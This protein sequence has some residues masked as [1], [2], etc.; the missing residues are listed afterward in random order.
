MLRRKVFYPFLLCFFPFLIHAQSK[1]EIA[2]LG[3]FGVSSFFNSS[4]GGAHGS[5]AVR[6][7][8][9]GKK[10]FNYYAGLTAFRNRVF[11]LGAFPLFG[12]DFGDYYRNLY[13]GGFVG[14]GKAIRFGKRNTIMPL[15]QSRVAYLAQ[16][17]LVSDRPADDLIFT[18]MP[19]DFWSPLYVDISPGVEWRI[20]IHQKLVIL[21]QERIAFHLN[22]AQVGSDEYRRFFILSLGGGLQF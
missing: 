2:I 6:F 22:P 3:D 8:L 15:L 20:P 18:G 4:A 5:V 10:N 14:F 16:K 7:E 19:E 13:V 21:L 9:P 1:P 11:Q 17:Q 12:R